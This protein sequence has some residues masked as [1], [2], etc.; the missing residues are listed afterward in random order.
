[1]RH[2]AQTIVGPDLDGPVELKNWFGFGSC[3]G[4]TAELS[5]KGNPP[6]IDNDYP[7]DLLA[8]IPWAKEAGLELVEV[9]DTEGYGPWLFITSDHWYCPH[10]GGNWFAF[11]N[12]DP[13]KTRGMFGYY[14]TRAAALKSPPP[15]PPGFVEV[16]AKA[17]DTSYDGGDSRSGP[18]VPPP[19]Q[20]SVGERLAQ[21]CYEAF[22]NGNP[23]EEYPHFAPSFLPAAQ[24]VRREV[25]A[26]PWAE[27]DIQ[28]ADTAFQASPGLESRRWV[29]AA[30]SAALASR[31]KRAEREG[32]K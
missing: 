15:K 28:A 3:W 20:P 1:M 2:H 13:V 12:D 16:K 24:A 6:P 21:V 30:L 4:G 8:A 26:E 5:T 25:L 29:V 7:S 10:S 27:E 11:G 9:K 18:G 32:S 19:A 14:P 17:V 22:H 23:P 31:C